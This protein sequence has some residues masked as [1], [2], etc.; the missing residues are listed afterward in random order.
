[1]GVEP[2]IREAPFRERA[3]VKLE[4]AAGRRKSAQHFAV[5]VHADRTAALGVAVGCGRRHEIGRIR[6]RR[7]R[8]NAAARVDVLLHQLAV[9]NNLFVKRAD[10]TLQ[11]ERPISSHGLERRHAF[12]RRFLSKSWHGMFKYVCIIFVNI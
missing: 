5:D 7:A 12:T 10:A 8:V 6:L 3:G 2:V 11:F 4:T 9:G 1:M